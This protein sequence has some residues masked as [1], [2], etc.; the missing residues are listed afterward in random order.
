MDQE[1]ALRLANQG[2]DFF[3]DHLDR[4]SDGDLREPSPLPGWSRAHVAA[5]VA[6]NAKAI[7]RLA[8]WART[9]VETKMY[10][11]MAARDAE[12]EEGAT[13][14]ADELRA[15][16]R[17]TD[18]AL[19][20][21]LAEMPA[22]AWRA[23][24]TTA[25]GGVVSASVIPWLRCREVW[26]H[27]VDLGVGVDYRDFPAEFVDELIEDVCQTWRDRGQ[28]PA[29]TLRPTDRAGEWHVDMPAARPHV[30]TGSA[31]ELAAWLTGRPARVTAADGALPELGLWL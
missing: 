15:L 29:L 14:P 16:V 30:V 10:P 13:L 1:F 8:Q 17:D 26:L 5:H 6:F 4:I 11:S 22:S 24:V 3:L 28:S 21:D 2:A 27:T 31:A 7:A 20:A 23:E 18:A 12:I 19:R 9:G 25:R